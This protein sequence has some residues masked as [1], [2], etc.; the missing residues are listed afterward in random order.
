[1]KVAI[2]KFYNEW[3]EN[4]EEWTIYEKDFY[5]WIGTENP[6]QEDLERFSESYLKDWG[7]LKGIE[8]YRCYFEEFD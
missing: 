8:Q 1:M 6:I 7:R 5:K 4:V 3:N 2:F